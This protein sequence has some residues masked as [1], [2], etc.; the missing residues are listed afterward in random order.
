MLRKLLSCLTCTF[1]FIS[2]SLK[3]Q[4][5]PSPQ[6]SAAL[7]EQAI[8]N[9]ASRAERDSLLLQKAEFLAQDGMYD[10]AFETLGRISNYGLDDDA[11][12]ELMRRKLIYLYSACRMDEFCGM[13]EEAAG[14]GLP[15]NVGLEGKPRHRN[16]DAAYILSA[17]P[18]VGLAY[19]GDWKNAAKYFLLDGSIIALGAGA[20]YCKLYVSAFLGSGMLLSYSLPKSTEMAVEAAGAYN[21]RALQEY[22]SHI[23]ESLLVFKK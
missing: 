14:Y 3:A 19:A 1:L 12:A 4:Q 9:C 20:L 22:Y 21:S 7:C 16:E 5:E 8:W 13:L 23:Y 11:R 10:K 6:L 2:F 18:G 15:V 17:I